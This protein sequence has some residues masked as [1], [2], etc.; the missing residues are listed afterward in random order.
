MKI[1]NFY[2]KNEE[3]A[4]MWSYEGPPF[5]DSIQELVMQLVKELVLRVSEIKTFTFNKVR[6]G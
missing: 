5:Q 3:G 4:K 1:F 6:L 2:V